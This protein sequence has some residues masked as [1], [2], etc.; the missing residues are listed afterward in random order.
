MVGIIKEWKKTS[1]FQ[2]LRSK[3]I[4]QLSFFL[5]GYE[6]GMMFFLAY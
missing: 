3:L 1:V 4:I 2:A 6:N 5:K